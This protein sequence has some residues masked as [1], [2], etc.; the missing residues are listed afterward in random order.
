MTP[1]PPV[2]PA[3]ANPA[4]DG[5]AVGAGAPATVARASKLISAPPALL[6]IGISPGPLLVGR[7]MPNGL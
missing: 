6:A 3:A 7:P 5:V 2:A 1:W 4:A